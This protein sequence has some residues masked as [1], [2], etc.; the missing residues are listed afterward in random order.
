MSVSLDQ[1][2]ASNAQD[3]TGTL[4]TLDFTGLTVGVGS[5]RGLVGLLTLFT[6]SA[7]GIKWDPVGTNQTVALITSHSQ[8]ASCITYI[9]GLVAPTS[10]NKILR[11]TWTGASSVV[12]S[13]ICFTGVDQTG[14]VTTFNN[15]TTAGA[16]EGAV[17]NTESIGPITTAT[18]DAIVTLFGNDTTGNWSSPDHTQIYTDTGAF[19]VGTF[20]VNQSSPQTFNAILSTGC[21]GSDW[22]AVATNIKAAAGGVVVTS[23]TFGIQGL[24]SSEW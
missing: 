1:N 21:G 11:A 3:F 20:E 24:A 22:A 15:S 4:T 8:G 23:G 12:L 2:P 16:F 18:T 9:F 5:N 13:A 6:G 14:G 10:G 19:T 7:P 17:S